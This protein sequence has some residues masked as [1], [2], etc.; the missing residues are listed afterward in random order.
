[1]KAQVINKMRNLYFTIPSVK[2]ENG[3]K[4]LHSRKGLVGSII[5][6]EKCQLFEVL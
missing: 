6:D 1:M 2:L 4:S 5:S 3:E